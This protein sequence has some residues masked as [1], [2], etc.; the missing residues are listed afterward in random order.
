MFL[1]VEIFSHSLFN[2]LIIPIQ[3]VWKCDYVQLRKVDRVIIVVFDLF[4]FFLF[5]NQWWF[6]FIL[7]RI[8]IWCH[9]ILYLLEYFHIESINV[10]YSEF[11]EVRWIVLLDVFKQVDHSSAYYDLECLVIWILNIF[12]IKISLV[13]QSILFQNTCFLP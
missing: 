6:L 10:V 9:I 5:P 3:E 12:N 13:Y 4:I 1:L 7:F 2:K 8:V 11:F